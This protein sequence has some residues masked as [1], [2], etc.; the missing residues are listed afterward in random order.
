MD[1][2]GQE[3]VRL[4]HDGPAV[5]R[6]EGALALPTHRW[7]IRRAQDIAAAQRHPATNPE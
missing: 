3:Q 1:E 4:V 6:G 7:S 2:P 5:A